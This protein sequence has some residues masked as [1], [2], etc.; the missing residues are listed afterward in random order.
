MTRLRLLLSVSGIFVAGSPPVSA[1]AAPT[2]VPDAVQAAAETITEADFRAKLGQLAH[3]S[4]RGRETPSPEL[5]KA[6]EWVAA[7][8]RNAGLEPAGD[9]GGYLQRFELASVRLDSQ[10]TMSVQGRDISATWILGSHLVLASSGFLDELADVPVVLLSGVPSD[11][12]RPFGDLAVGG[13]AVLHL[14][15]LEDAQGSVLNS[16]LSR[17]QA[18]GAVAWIVAAEIPPQFWSQLEGASFAPRWDLVEEQD[19]RR[20][21]MVFG[22]QAAAAEPVIRAAGADPAA[23]LTPEGQTVRH[24]EGITLSLAPHHVTEQSVSVANV[25]G[26]LEGSD[27]ALCD[28]AVIFTAHFDHVGDIQGGRCRPSEALPADSVCNGA[29]DNAS[30]TVGVIEL[31]EAYAA[32]DPRP[33]RTLIFAAVTAEERGLCGSRYYVQH[34]VVAIEQTVAVVNLDMIARN[35]PDTVGFVGREYT[36]LGGLVDRVVLDHPELRLTPTEHDGSFPNSDHYSFA[37]RGV[38]A[39]FFFSGE[40]DDLHTAADNPERADVEQAARV[41]RLAFFVGLEVANAA[42]RPTWD[43]EAR[44]RIVGQ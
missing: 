19:A 25:V 11:T 8:F 32:L 40:H 3:D 23:L 34:P 7:Q 14:I 33:A 2:R 39:L 38:P 36:S 31:A 12:A 20:G 28:E 21:F 26:M 9:A 27:P 37:S 16:L 4:T 5:E 30:G 44:A 17:A 6:T 41:A 43:P 18:E 13:A 10:T 42:Q 1:Q 24:L 22:L 35:A 15:S 29:D